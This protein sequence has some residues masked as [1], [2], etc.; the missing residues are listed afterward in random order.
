MKENEKKVEGDGDYGEVRGWSSGDGGWCCD[1]ESEDGGGGERNT[2]GDGGDRVVMVV[3]MMLEKV[4]ELSSEWL[5]REKLHTKSV[6]FEIN[7]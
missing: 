7:I 5:I 2:R 6:C 3:K 1:D 4:V